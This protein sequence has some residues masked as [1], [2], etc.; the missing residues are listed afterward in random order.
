M[1]LD[2]SYEV[3]IKKLRDLQREFRSNFGVGDILTNSK[4][5]EVLIANKLDH[6][7]IPGHSGSRDAKSGIFQFE[8]KHFKESSSN[9]SWTFN[10]FSHS[11]ISKL[12]KTNTVAI[13]AHIDD[14]KWPPEFDWM[15]R[16]TGEAMSEYLSI[17]TKSINNARKMINVSPRQLEERLNAKREKPQT[18]QGIYSKLL[19]Q[20]F[21]VIRQLE[22]SE[23]V[24]GLLTSNKIWELLVAKELNHKVNSEQGGRIGAHDAYDLKGGCYEYKVA[25]R[26][27]WSFQDISTTVLKKYLR[28]KAIIC[29]VV[30]KDNLEVR[31]IYK[32]DPKRVVKAL[33]LELELKNDRLKTSGKTLRR[34]QVSLSR[35]KIQSLDPIQIK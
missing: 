3:L 30:D 35:A 16:L 32:L 5:Y 22:Q 25:K 33:Q 14:T 31:R 8:Y 19:N 20:L 13:F 7:L 21:E 17:H 10:D 29:A 24:T 23:S 26:E 11:T 34:F 2:S 4:L 28:T 9:H 6:Q 27:T 1:E 12:G 15:Y 18:S